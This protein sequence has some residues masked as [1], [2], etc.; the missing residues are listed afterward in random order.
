[1]SFPVPVL[2]PR[3]LSPAEEKGLRAGLDGWI[4][5]YPESLSLKRLFLR[6]H[7]HELIVALGTGM[8]RSNQYA[9]KWSDHVDF[10]GRNIYLPPSMTKTGKAQ[11]IPMID[12]VHEA[13]V[14]LKSIQRELATLRPKCA[15]NGKP[16]RM[17]SNGRVF[18]I[19]ENREW[20][21]MALTEA[22]SAD[23]R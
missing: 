23:F 21:K 2:N 9:I 19:T 6:C 15:S 4:R 12:D 18:N 14:E 13:L 11:N 3:F 8:R 5:D 17:R 1:M 16:E 22:K 10:P 7:P 20:W